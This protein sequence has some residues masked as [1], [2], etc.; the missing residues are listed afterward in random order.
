LERTGGRRE[1]SGFRQLLLEPGLTIF[2]ETF[3]TASFF[4]AILLLV[5]AL[6]EDSVKRG[7]LAGACPAAACCFRAQMELITARA[8][9][10]PAS[11]RSWRKASFATFARAL[12][13]TAN[14]I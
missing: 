3:A 10:A 14:C 2:A 7:A 13:Y 5:I 6:D 11:D 4:S 8:A 1:A 12:S 9:L